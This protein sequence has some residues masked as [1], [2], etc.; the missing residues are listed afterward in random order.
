MAPWEESNRPFSEDEIE[1]YSRLKSTHLIILSIACRLDEFLGR[2][3]L[4]KWS[5]Q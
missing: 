3:T 2:P 4:F 5:Y 1:W